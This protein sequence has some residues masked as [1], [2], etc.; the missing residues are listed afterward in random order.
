MA[1]PAMLQ[2]LGARLAW[3][4]PLKRPAVE[5]RRF[6]CALNSLPVLAELLEG[7]AEATKY[8]TTCLLLQ[9]QLPK[10]T[11][12]SLAAFHQL[13][14]HL[15]SEGFD[16]SGDTTAKRIS[17]MTAR[18]KRDDDL[19][20]AAPYG[21]TGSSGKGSEKTALEP[22]P[23]PRVHIKASAK[24][25]QLWLSSPDEAGPIAYT[26]APVAATFG[27]APV[28][29][30]PDEQRSG[31]GALITYYHELDDRFEVL[32][33]AL[34]RR[35]VPLTQ[36]VVFDVSTSHPVFGAISSARG[37]LAA[38]VSAKLATLDDGTLEV[39]C[40]E[41]WRASPDFVQKV[42]ADK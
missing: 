14:H 23:K 9:S 12:P 41:L 26:S 29:G 5:A 15:A 32:R 42:I 24:V 1:F 36:A 11:V 25:L 10:V 8:G 39:E 37:V 19:R 16:L 31:I 28:V 17:A 30:V 3:S 4:D 7:E 35:S 40:D 33:I 34:A 6:S 27:V 22:N 38:Y 21:G 20:A 2:D 18:D 13:D